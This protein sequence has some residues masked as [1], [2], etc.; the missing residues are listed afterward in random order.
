MFQQ[1][2]SDCCKLTLGGI[3]VLLQHVVKWAWLLE[4]TNQTLGRE[5]RKV[6]PP[7]QLRAAGSQLRIAT[8]YV[9]VE[10]WEW[11][12]LRIMVSWSTYTVN[13]TATLLWVFMLFIYLFTSYSNSQQ[14]P[15]PRRRM[16]EETH[17]CTFPCKL[18][19]MYVIA[20]SLDPRPF[21]SL[22]SSLHIYQGV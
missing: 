14:C 3:F 1:Q 12:F 19:M 17:Q 11:L 2:K 6:A 10:Q 20:H 22:W 13:I 15:W 21:C 5:F 16:P 9:C 18:F 7:V 4:S 8:A